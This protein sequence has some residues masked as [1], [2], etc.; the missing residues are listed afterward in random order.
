MQQNCW[1]NGKA[2]ES[3]LSKLFPVLP[4]AEEVLVTISP[5]TWQSTPSKRGG[6]CPAA[7]FG[8]CY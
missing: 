5:L 3:N 6:V 8:P 2:T 1:H 7:N 4:L